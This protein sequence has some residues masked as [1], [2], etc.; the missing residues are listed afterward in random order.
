MN[1]N[2]FL[3]EAKKFQVG[4]KWEWNHVDGT[5]TVEITEIKPNGDI[6]GKIE[7]TS[8][9]FI[10]RDANKYLKKKVNESIV[11]EKLST[12]ETK[13]VAETL[14]K[15][16]SKHDG[17]KCTVNTKSLEEG[18]FDLDVDGEEYD[19]GSYYI[20]DKGEVVN[21]AITPHEVY[22]T[23]NS[24]VEDFI[25]GLKKPVKESLVTEGQFFKETKNFED[26][27]EEIDGMPENRIR[28]IMGKDYIDTPGGYRDEADDYNNDIVDYTLS[29]MG[30]KDFDKLKAWWENNVKESFLDAYDKDSDELDESRITI[31]RRYTDNH[32]AQTVGKFAAIRNKVLEAIKDGKISNEEFNTILKE[33]TKDSSRW[34]K[35][36][37]QYFNVSEDGVS[38]SKFGMR[39]LKSITV[40]E[41]TTKNPKIWVPGGFDKE[42]GKHPNSKITRKLVLD[43]AKKWDVA[44]ED[45]ISYVEFGWAI[46]LD[47]NKQNN[48]MENTKFIYESFSEFV[49]NKLNEN[50]E[51]LLEALKSSILSGFISMYAAPKDLYKAF[52]QYTKV[53]LN[54]I[55]DTDF[56]EMAPSE[57]YKSKNLGPSIVFYVSQNE[58][59]NPYASAEG[60]SNGMIPGN[61]LL[62]IANGQNEFFALQFSRYN[63]VYDGRGKRFRAMSNVGKDANRKD[64]VGISKDYK[65]WNASGL[66]NVKRI[67][68][69][70]DIA[71]VLPLEVIRAKYSVEA[72]KRQREEAKRGATAMMDPRKIKDDNISK[73]KEILAQRLLSKDEAIDKEVE[74]VVNGVNQFI[75]DGFAAKQMSQYGEII[76]GHDPKGREVRVSDATNYLKNVLE[77]YAKYVNASNA[78]ETAKSKGGA[79]W[80]VD[81][82]EKEIKRH[83]LSTREYLKKW[84]DKT[85]NI[86]W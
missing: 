80:E 6:V 57:A 56:I 71:Y 66:S 26:F 10:V 60:Y 81:Y 42:I 20:N 14:A 16:I 9:T 44:P 18:S 41:A 13:K 15:A 77:Y 43:A 8:E 38:L 40:N 11:N 64:T 86:A 74:K 19:G 83:T 4:D 82:Q 52:Y 2:Q 67:S 54:A 76:L 85:P 30:Q 47:E 24:S 37:A 29:N 65:G 12:S 3:N 25:K 55:E 35:R 79:K 36:N 63:I 17:C 31:K 70:A 59:V 78:L 73:Y 45:A 39:I 61:A 28:R 72:L 50:N 53:D 21:A 1:F 69:V 27:L 75:M 22:G 33:M 51:S 5:K 58:K 68:E 32:P 49:E 46:D 48:N 7:G 34:L 62:A 23:V 84:N